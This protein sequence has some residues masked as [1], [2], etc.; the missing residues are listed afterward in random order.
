MYE[1]AAS[2]ALLAK[3]VNLG[4]DAMLG[5]RRSPTGT[6]APTQLQWHGARRVRE[7]FWLPTRQVRL[8]DW[9]H[10]LVRDKGGSWARCLDLHQFCSA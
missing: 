10:G 2:S 7:R 1:I 8:L 6:N 4:L 3:T 5:A 9:L